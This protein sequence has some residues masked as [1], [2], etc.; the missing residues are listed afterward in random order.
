MG[1]AAVLQSDYLTQPGKPGSGMV[2]RTS[3]FKYSLVAF[4]Q[5]A[6]LITQSFPSLRMPPAQPF[7]KKR[8]IYTKEDIV[9]SSRRE[10]TFL[11]ASTL[12]TL[13]ADLLGSLLVSHVCRNR[14]KGTRCSRVALTWSILLKCSENFARRGS[15]F[16]KTPHSS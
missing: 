1:L 2:K 8:K 15:G 14:A 3:Y 16:I 11:A 10:L 4:F 6:K 5:I 13:G 9:K 12:A 7:R